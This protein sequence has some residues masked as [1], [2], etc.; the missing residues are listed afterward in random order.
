FMKHPIV[1]QHR[2]DGE[3]NHRQ[4]KLGT[5]VPVNIPQSV[6]RSFQK[7]R[8]REGA[9]NDPIPVARQKNQGERGQYKSRKRIYQYRPAIHPI[10]QYRFDV[11]TQNKAKHEQPAQQKRRDGI[12]QSPPY[13]SIKFLSNQFTGKGVE[14][15]SS[16]HNSRK[17]M[18]KNVL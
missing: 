6:D 16:R 9:R 1:Q 3:E 7:Y 17:I 12:R 8:E 5:I 11:K 13:S 18:M 14:R 10:E 2:A 4:Y 15:R